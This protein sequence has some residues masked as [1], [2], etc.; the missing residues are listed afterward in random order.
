MDLED[1][2]LREIRQTKSNTYDFIHKWKIKI[3]NECIDIQF[4]LMLTR[5]EG[6]REEDE[7]GKR[8]LCTVMD[9]NQSVGGEHGAVYTEIKIYDVHL[10]FI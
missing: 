9:G 4:R 5:G 10:K 2:M 6:R 8:Y 7:R 3:T 1:I